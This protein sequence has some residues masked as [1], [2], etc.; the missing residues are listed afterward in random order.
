MDP[1]HYHHPNPIIH[2]EDNDAAELATFSSRGCCCFF[3]PTPS[4][5]SRVR[6]SSSSSSPT[7][8][9]PSGL[10]RAGVGA[11]MKVREWSELIAGPRWKTFIR[12][13][14]RRSPSFNGTI[15]NSGGSGGGQHRRNGSFGY[16]PLSYAL[17]FDDGGDL[18]SPDGES[19][20]YPDF[21]AR[22][23]KPPVDLGR[24]DASPLFAPPAA[25]D[26]WLG[27]PSFLFLFLSISGIFVGVVCAN[28]YLN[29]NNNNS[30]SNMWWRVL[31]VFLD[32]L[33]FV[34]V[35]M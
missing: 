34:G 16:D 28:V 2:E 18:R 13:F 17:N 9:S 4:S 29:N 22:F 3:I 15:I 20:F 26:R 14:N 21:S 19:G 30:S 35:Y 5:W 24:R 11:L 27:L 1:H 25:G 6:S 7:S 12:R 33:L 23:A 8:R 10:W 31:Y 32:V